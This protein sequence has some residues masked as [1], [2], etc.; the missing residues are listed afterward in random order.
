M[1][2]I[3]KLEHNIESDKHATT[4]AAFTWYTGNICVV[5]QIDQCY[6]FIAVFNNMHTYTYMIT[7]MHDNPH[8]VDPLHTHLQVYL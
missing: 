8:I 1:R 4:V 7:E 2:S 6:Q 3:N 5:L